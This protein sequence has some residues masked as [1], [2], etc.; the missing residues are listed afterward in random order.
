MTSLV[1]VFNHRYERNLDK[2]ET[3]Y[4]RRFSRRH[5]LM[6]FYGGDR[7]EV[8]PVFGRSTEFQGFFA[9]ARRHIVHPEVTHYAFV[10]DDLI[11]NPALDQDNLPERLGLPRGASFISNRILLHQLD[12]PWAHT[13][14]AFQ[15]FTRA[16][17]LEYGP[18]MPDAAEASRRLAAHGLTLGP[19]PRRHLLPALGKPSLRG[20]SFGGLI[21]SLSDWAGRLTRHL[22]AAHGTSPLPYPLVGGYSDFIVVDAASLR[23]FC[24]LCG[25]FA[26]LGLFVELAAPTALHLACPRVLTEDDQGIRMKGR[27]IWS[28]AEEVELA[29]L[30]GFSLDRLLAAYPPDLTYIHPIKLSQWH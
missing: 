23:T 11:L 25:V 29:G 14:K 15:I 12:R 4:S 6:P 21:S 9:Q 27:P 20:R 10:G 1:V 3:L 2:L 16:E 13:A 8:I 24:D 26:S 7:P 5:Y 19:V 28:R 30:H 18:L 22:S 17:G